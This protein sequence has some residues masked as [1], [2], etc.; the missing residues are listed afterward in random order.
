M[1]VTWN[2]NHRIRGFF[3]QATGKA[4]IVSELI[5]EDVTSMSLSGNLV[6]VRDPSSSF[7]DLELSRDL[8][9]RNTDLPFAD[10]S[11]K[12]RDEIACEIDESKTANWWLDETSGHLQVGFVPVSPVLRWVQLGD[13]EVWLGLGAESQL[14]AL[15]CKGLMEDESGALEKQWLDEIGA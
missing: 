10:E 7:C 5:A 1:R 2:G 13:N 11:E 4:T 15:V 9:Y 3:A 12:T 8:Q 6:L 14:T